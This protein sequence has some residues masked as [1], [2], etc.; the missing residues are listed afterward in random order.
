MLKGF[1][2]TAQNM[3]VDITTEEMYLIGLVSRKLE[4]PS[5]FV[6]KCIAEY[7][8]MLRWYDNCQSNPMRASRWIAAMEESH[9]VRLARFDIAQIIDVSSKHR[10]DKEYQMLH[11]KFSS[12]V[13]SGY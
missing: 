12:Y 2:L 5:D 4:R 1:P 8:R 11:T 9:N 13:Q 6:L 3:R 10:K 7:K